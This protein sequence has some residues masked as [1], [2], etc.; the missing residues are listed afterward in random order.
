MQQPTLSTLNEN[1]LQTI[2]KKLEARSVSTFRNLTKRHRTVLLPTLV[3]IL[4]QSTSGL[5]SLLQIAGVGNENVLVE[6]ARLMEHDEGEERY[7]AVNALPQHVHE[8]DERAITAV[9]ARLEDT[10]GRVRLAAVQAFALIA[11]KGNAHAIA[12]GTA[13]LQHANAYVRYAYAYVR[14]ISL[15][16]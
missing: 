4:A 8:G 2:G 1:L 12:E 13:R 11:Q 9:A 7:R 10:N 15:G 6:V 14:P 3:K 5:K 16:G